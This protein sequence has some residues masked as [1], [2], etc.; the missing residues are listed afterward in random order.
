MYRKLVCLSLIA[1]MCALSIAC[2]KETDAASVVNELDAFTKELVSKVET[3]P[4]AAGV[5]EAQK[6][7]DS[8]NAAL[9]TKLATLRND[10]AARK[11]A[12]EAV[13][14]NAVSVSRL[15]LN[16]MTNRDPAFK[17]KLDKLIQDYQNL[18]NVTGI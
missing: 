10:E 3:N 14:G 12:I 1:A 5:D 4:T 16:T 18:I 11:R 9:S 6:F 15:Q 17:S 7:F 8:K 13:N 2:R